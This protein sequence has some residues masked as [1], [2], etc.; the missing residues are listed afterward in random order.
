MKEGQSSRPSM[1]RHDYWLKVVRLGRFELPT[2]CF[3]G[4]RSI[5]LSYSR[6]P[7]LYH[8]SRF[9]R[10]PVLNFRMDLSCRADKVAPTHALGDR[11]SIF[12]AIIERPRTFTSMEMGGRRLLPCTISPRTQVLPP[13]APT[14][15]GSYT[16]LSH[17]LTTMGWPAVYLYFE[18][19]M[20]RSVT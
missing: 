14:F 9:T 16:V 11:Y 15:K 17:G 4:T 10:I 6:V 5:H 3:G 7:P 2:S 1:N 19:S 20:A 13:S 18:A 12:S 8:A